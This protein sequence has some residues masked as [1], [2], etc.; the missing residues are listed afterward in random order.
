MAHF[1]LSAHLALVLPS[2]SRLDIFDLKCPSVRR[3]NEERLE[4]VVG[5]ERVPVHRQYVGVSPPDPRY[6]RNT[7]TSMC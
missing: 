4:P 1:G 6:L 2:V 7:G 3:F 5:D